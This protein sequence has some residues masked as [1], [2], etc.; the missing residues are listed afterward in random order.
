MNPIGL[1]QQQQELRQYCQQIAFLQGKGRA[2]AKRKKLYFQLLRRVRR[3]RVRLLRDLEL[4]G[5]NLERRTDLPP[6]RRLMA[7]EVLCLIA[8]DLAALEQVANV[9]QRRIMAQEK[10]PVAEKII[11]LSDSDASF[12][13]KGGWDTVVGYRPPS[14]AQRTWFCHGAFLTSGQ[15]S[16]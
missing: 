1:L 3:L 4:V 15:H 16:R 8:E 6:S 9:C 13:V 12:I 5:R 7:E 10:V 11:S 2:E 14:G